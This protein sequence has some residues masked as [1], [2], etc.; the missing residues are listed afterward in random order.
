MD[1]KI[2]PDPYITGTEKE[3]TYD[4]HKI[5]EEACHKKVISRTSGHAF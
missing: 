5:D 2:L 4:T 3:R 1:L